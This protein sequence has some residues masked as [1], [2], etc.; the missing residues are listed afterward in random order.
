MRSGDGDHAYEFISLSKKSS[1]PVAVNVSCSKLYWVST[2]Q[3]TLTPSSPVKPEAVLLMEATAG[4]QPAGKD[5]EE[6]I[7]YTAHPNR[8]ALTRSATLAGCT[9][10]P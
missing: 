4:Q 7:T 8:A 5:R 2:K 1:V 10:N 6:N 9:K 3:L